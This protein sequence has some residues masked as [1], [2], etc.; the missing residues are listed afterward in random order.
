[1][2]KTCVIIPCYNEEKRLDTASFLKF[3]EFNS[4]DFLFVNDGSTDATHEILLELQNK[5][6]ENIS[7]LKLKQNKGKAEAVRRGFL[8]AIE[9]KEYTVIGY[10]DA[11]LATPLEEIPYLLNQLTGDY[12]VVMG[13]RVKRLG[14]SIQR[15]LSRHYLGRIFATFSS[16]FL[17]I[18]VYDSQCG[19]KFFKSATAKILFA[20]PFSSKWLFDLELIYRFK[21]IKQDDFNNHIIEIPLRKWEEK[22]SSKMKPL[23]FIKAP[24][25]VFKI[26]SK[27]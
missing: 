19:A 20:K 26:K 15:N 10:M 5:I 2:Q 7:I 22:H 18:K 11:D 24:L 12:E 3:I 23:D 25:D 14:T 4:Y 1:M 16:F 17:K 6:P 13:A 8:T 9:N 27:N 21:K